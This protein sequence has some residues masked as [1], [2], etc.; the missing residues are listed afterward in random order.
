MA[1]G[2]GGPVAGHGHRGR[3]HGPRVARSF[4]TALVSRGW[5]PSTPAAILWGAGTSAFA[6]WIG[7]LADLGQAETPP[8]AKGAAG[9]IVVGAVVGLASVLGGASSSEWDEEGP[10]AVSA[11]SE[12]G[13]HA[14]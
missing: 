9:T 13:L 14:R 8:G 10:A 12:G 4:A 3:P 7:P 1:A 5:A 6:R 2:A 11:G